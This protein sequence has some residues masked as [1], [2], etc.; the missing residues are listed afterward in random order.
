MVFLGG[1]G[2]HQI[3]LVGFFFRAGFASIDG[4]RAL[5]LIIESPAKHDVL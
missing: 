2:L 5:V 1:F 4:N 3:S